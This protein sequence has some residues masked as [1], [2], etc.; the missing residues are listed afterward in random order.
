MMIRRFIDFLRDRLQIVTYFFFGGIAA[1]VIWSLTVDL[2]HAHTWAEQ[3]IPAF[4]GIF[5][6][7]S[8]IV[9][10][11]FT[12]WFGRGGIKTREDYYDN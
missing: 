2:H 7:I 1:V 12:R 11:F 4:W 10:I 3:H 8:T 6:I 9:I 5:A